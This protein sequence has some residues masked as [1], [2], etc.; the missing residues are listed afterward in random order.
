V[1]LTDVRMP[2]MD[3]VELLGR[4]KA[5][6]PETMVVLMTAYGTVKTAVKA[7]KLGRRGLPLEAD[8]RRG[9]RGRAR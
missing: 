1:V 4:V 3:G 7:M 2:G 5:L 6:R 9:A 8:R